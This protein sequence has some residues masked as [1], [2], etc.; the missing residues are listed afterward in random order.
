MIEAESD[1]DALDKAT[2]KYGYCILTASVTLN[3]S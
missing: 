1:L 2:T 3:N